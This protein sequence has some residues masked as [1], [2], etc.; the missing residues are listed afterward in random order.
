MIKFGLLGKSLKFDNVV[1][2][3]K[4]KRKVSALI[5]YTSYIIGHNFG[6]QKINGRIQYTTNKQ[7][8]FDTKEFYS[9]KIS[10]AK[11]LTFKIFYITHN[12]SPVCAQTLEYFGR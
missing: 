11:F 10:D 8:K 5:W 7:T 12:F 6:Q 4:V 1:V 3:I 9:K 2:C